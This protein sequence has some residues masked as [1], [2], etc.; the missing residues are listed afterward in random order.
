VLSAGDYTAIATHEGKLFEQD[1]TVEAGLN[2]DVEVL[3]Q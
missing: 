1:F 3:V 2:R